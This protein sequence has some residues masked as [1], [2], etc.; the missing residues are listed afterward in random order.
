ME[1]LLSYLK[2]RTVLTVILIFLVNGVAGVQEFI[3]EA[4]LPIVNAI[5]S[6]LT[7]YFRVSPKQV[8]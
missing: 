7:I 4:Y 5:L 1:K 3:P 8:F 6:L 2:S